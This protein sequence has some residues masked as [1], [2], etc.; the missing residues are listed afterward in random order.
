MAERGI[1]GFEAV[2]QGQ[3]GTGLAQVFDTSNLVQAAV[4]MRQF[5]QQQFDTLIS[6]LA[7]IDPKLAH[8]KDTEDIIYGVNRLQDFVV[9]NY[10]AIAD[11][12][13]NPEKAI[14]FRRMKNELLAGLHQSQKMGETAINYTDE[15]RK[16]DL[17]MG[18]FDANSQLIQRFNTEKVFTRDEN[19]NLVRNNAATSLFSERLQI[20]KGA[21][22]FATELADKTK[23]QFDPNNPNLQ[24]IALPNGTFVMLSPD[25][26]TDTQADMMID[27]S[28]MGGGV[29]GVAVVNGVLGIEAPYEVLSEAEKQ[30]VRDAIRPSFLQ[31]L[32]TK[33]ITNVVRNQS[34][35]G[36]QKT[37]ANIE[38][39]ERN[40]VGI[41]AGDPAALGNLVGSKYAQTGGDIVSVSPYTNDNGELVMAFEVVKNNNR[42]VHEHAY[43]KLDEDG[44]ALLADDAGAKY[45]AS[46]NSLMNVANMTLNEPLP[47]DVKGIDTER[48]RGRVKDALRAQIES[49]QFNVSIAEGRSFRVGDA[50]IPEAQLKQTLGELVT[51]GMSQ[52]N[53]NQS[54]K[55]NIERWAQQNGVNLANVTMVADTNNPQIMNVRTGAS[56]TKYN[57]S[58]E[59]GRDDLVN[60]IVRT[61]VI[62]TASPQS[63]RLIPVRGGG[64]KPTQYNATSSFSWGT[65]N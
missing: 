9:E 21:N 54:V 34:I 50:S 15:M 29:D 17:M 56:E 28:L 14:E 31:R 27:N 37:E 7:D 2:P 26:I 6:S 52:P 33:P 22:E 55:G 41:Y 39:R 10:Q 63:T 5:K 35:L 51:T 57:V 60:L 23:P 18:A 1:T 48:I 25:K 44:N 13:K 3:I 58:T 12:R 43:G 11:P 32:D 49:G 24:K 45:D 62:Q 8:P 20:A 59:K 61:S 4:Q 36:Q 38:V 46:F 42:S 64:T 65:T 47:G 16:N 19:G 40:L 53:K 30:Q